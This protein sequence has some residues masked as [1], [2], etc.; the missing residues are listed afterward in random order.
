MT[1]G[2]Q[3]FDSN[4]NITLNISDNIPRMVTSGSVTVPA[5]G[6]VTQTVSSSANTSNSIVINDANVTSA[7]TSTGQV[8][9][10]SNGTSTTTNYRVLVL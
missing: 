1:Y 7:V 2:L 10:Y 6:T 4:G 8:T 5:S 3:V 9:F